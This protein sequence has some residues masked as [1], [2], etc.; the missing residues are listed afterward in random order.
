[1]DGVKEDRERHL[2]PPAITGAFGAI[3]R[4]HR[5][6]FLASCWLVSRCKAEAEAEMLDWLERH[7]FFQITGIDRRHVV[8]CR[9]PSDKAEICRELNVTHFVDDR[10]AVLRHMIGVVPNLYRFLSRASKLEAVNGAIQ[11]IRTI[12]TWVEITDALLD[13]VTTARPANNELER[14]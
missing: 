12:H 5:E 4:L 6:R 10:L 14:T 3:A 1:M 8:F 9:V 13:S 2:D 11:G 7:R